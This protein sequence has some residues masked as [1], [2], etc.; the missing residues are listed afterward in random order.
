MPA[1]E[2][3]PAPETFDADVVDR[4]RNAAETAAD[5]IWRVRA[6]RDTARRT[7]DRLRERLRDAGFPDR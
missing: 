2:P 6:E 3:T 4:L 7:V 5:V 1:P